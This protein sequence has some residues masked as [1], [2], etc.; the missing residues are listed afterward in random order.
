[1]TSTGTPAHVGRLE[2]RV[3]F[4]YPPGPER[5]LYVS[6]LREAGFETTPKATVA[7]ANEC[8]QKE[9]RPDV[10]VMEL[11]PD[12]IE[13]WTFVEQRCRIHSGVPLIILTSLVRPDRLNRRRARAIG[14]AA[15]VAKPCSLVQLV[16]VV[17]LV[18]SGVRGLEIS[19]Y[20]EARTGDAP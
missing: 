9:E 5:D 18:R 20:T 14:C 4:V 10:V 15:F 2:G 17:S 1:V 7:A 19:T 8:L 11:L 13:A 16:D 6:A 12:P 3:L